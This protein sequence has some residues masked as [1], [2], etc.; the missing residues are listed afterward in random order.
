M[1]NKSKRPPKRRVGDVDGPLI[2]KKPNKGFGQGKKG[3]HT[4]GPEPY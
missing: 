4:G 2:R 3:P 1:V